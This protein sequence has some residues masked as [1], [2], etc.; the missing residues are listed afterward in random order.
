MYYRLALLIA[1]TPYTA[2]LQ[3]KF[4]P[5]IN[6]GEDLFGL[7]AEEERLRATQLGYS[8]LLISPLVAT[9]KR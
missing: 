9:T 4:L 7:T 3:L 8:L 5:K 6:C 1:K 2:D